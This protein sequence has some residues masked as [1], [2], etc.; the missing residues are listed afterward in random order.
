MS[1]SVSAHSDGRVRSYSSQDFLNRELSWLTFNERVLHEAFDER[2]PLLE[3]LKFIAIFSTNLDEFYMVRVAGLR[4]QVAA[5]VQQAPPDGMTPRAQLDAISDRVAGLIARQQQ[6][7]HNLLLPALHE[8]G[9]RLV[10][11]ADLSPAEWLMVDGYFESQVFPVL[12]PLAV[13]PGHPFPYISNLS[14][15]L[16][17]EIRDPERD[18]TRFARVKIPPSLPR[19]VPIGRANHFVPL[20]QVVGANLGSLFPGMEVLEWHPFRITRYSDLDVALADEGDDL[21]E[22][23]EQQVLQRRFGEV[24]RVEVAA[25]MPEDMRQVLLEELR[26]DE[27]GEEGMPVTD[28][29]VHAAGSLL[30]L[31]D[32]MALASLDFPHLRDVPLLQ[33]TPPELRDPDSSIFDVLREQDM[34]VHHP[35]HSFENTVEHFLEAAAEDPQV[36]AVKCTLYRTSGDTEIVRALTDAAARGKQVAVLVEL[37][38][39]F[40]EANNINWARTLE[41]HGVHVAY[42]LQGLKTHTKTALVVR[43]E[44]DG[45][46]RY[47]HIGTGNYNTKTAR[48]YTDIGLLSSSPSLAAD[49][50]DLFNMITGFSRQKLYRKLL[51]APANLRARTLE[52]IAREVKNALEG[53]DAHIIAKMNSLVDAEV[54]GALYDAS[55]AG[56]EIDL[57][58][59]GICCLRP[60]VPGLSDRIR[61]TSIIGRFLE[62]S[63][64]FYYHN[65]GEPEYYIGSADW[66][67]RNL[68][69]RVEAV[70]PVERPELKGR[71]W[72]LLQVCL[73]DDR[74]AW[75]MLP[76]GSYSQ[77]EPGLG[78][79][80]ATHVVLQGDPWGEA[81]GQPTA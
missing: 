56:V 2:N 21:L 72:S 9:L 12:T 29:D 17:V 69:R 8:E 51:V 45:I 64:I 63:R 53:R 24:V 37:Q 35:F 14:L 39:R 19:W 30:E 41:D 50:S 76:D 55:S 47:F 70:A 38:A 23:I 1:S 20:E 52:L 28:R 79:T 3:R 36:L 80:R 10:T 71:L 57:I 75:D 16:A 18:I 6:C 46:R 25:D 42:G 73:R 31:G 34:L 60:G 77:R 48:T 81:S 26:D 49:L 78:P 54:I 11:M 61:V 66:M 32:L 22:A 59:R 58:V 62:H 13:D 68:D 33:V 4:R 43:R 74:Q 7:L 67:P 65:D 15:S 27:E 40:D 5:G 44:A